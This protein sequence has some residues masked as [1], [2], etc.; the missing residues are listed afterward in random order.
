MKYFLV[1]VLIVSSVAFGKATVQEYKTL[2]DA[3]ESFG[4]NMSFSREVTIENI[5]QECLAKIKT[6]KL[7]VEKTR[8][9]QSKATGYCVSQWK[10]LQ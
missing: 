10:S 6:V 7:G 9:M 2:K 4:I 5:E 8:D 3:A 1:F